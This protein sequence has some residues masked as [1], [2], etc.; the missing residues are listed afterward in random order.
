MLK[1]LSIS[2]TF[3][4]FFLHN[5]ISSALRR[6]GGERKS[7]SPF[8]PI[9]A[10]EIEA[11]IGILYVF[12]SFFSSKLAKKWGEFIGEGLSYA[13]KLLEGLRYSGRGFN[14]HFEAEQCLNLKRSLLE[15]TTV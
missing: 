6:F 4:A 2:L 8:Q 13:A 9:V 14:C 3:F 11:F 15:S 1:N 10:N 5:K 7:P 12:H